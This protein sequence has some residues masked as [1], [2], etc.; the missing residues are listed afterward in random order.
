MVSFLEPSNS[1]ELSAERTLMTQAANNPIAPGVANAPVSYG[2]FEITVGI[3]P[4][5]PGATELLDLVSDS[6]YGG[7]DLGP[8]SYLGSADELGER[9][10]SRGLGLSGGYLQLAFSDADRL[11]EQLPELDALLDVFD[12]TAPHVRPPYPTLADAGSDQRQRHPGRAASDRTVGLDDQLWGT[13]VQG[14]ERVLDRCRE[15][16]YEPTFHPH[17]GTFVEAGWEIDR[18]LETTEI[19]ICFDPGHLLVGRVDPL[20]AL[21]AWS[22]RINHIHLKDAFTQILD[23]LL[24]AD[25]PTESIYASGAFCPLGAG[26]VDMDAV[27]AHIDVS[28]FDGWL[29]VEQDLVPTSSESVARA[30]EEQRNNR[31]FLRKRG[32]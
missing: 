24:A 23:D 18:L 6:G 10:T 2:A 7:I 19:G 26:A 12:A 15:R 28:G 5:V 8:I 13:F 1:S 30:A 16:G 31:A 11:A 4:H 29:V 3:N 25:E 32:F 27:L 22:D 9:L 14:V 17:A 21:A 20:P